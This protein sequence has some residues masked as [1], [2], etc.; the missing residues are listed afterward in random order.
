MAGNPLENDPSREQRIRERAYQLWEDE[1]KPHGRDVEYWERARE[2]V[3]MEDSAGAALL[4]NPQT[5]PESRRET[6]IE[7]AEIQ[8]NL[9]EFPDRFADQG[10]VQPTPQPKRRAPRRPR[11]TKA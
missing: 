11:K 3:G 9:G 6:G 4:P 5:H 8:Q 2:L 1:G 10:D 7:E